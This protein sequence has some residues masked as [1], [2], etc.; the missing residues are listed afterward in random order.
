M[1]WFGFVS[2]AIL[3]ILTMKVA[4][5]GP[6]GAPGVAPIE[7]VVLGTFHFDNPGLDYASVQV[8]DVL[9]P[10]RQAQIGDLLDHL[11][12]YV[13]TK[14][15]VESQKRV[16]G[17][18]YSA[19]YRRF[20]AGAAPPNRSEVTQL[21]YRL[22]QRLRHDEVYATDFDGEFPFEPVMDW[23]KQ[24]G[25]EGQ[26]EAML[27]NTRERAAALS[28]ELKTHSLEQVLRLLNSRDHLRADHGF[29]TALL[30]F[31]GGDEQPG[32]RLV[33]AWYA[34]N[35]GICARIV[36]VAQPGDRLLVIYGAGHAWLLR[37]CLAEQPG[38]RILEADAFLRAN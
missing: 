21:G 8:D 20:L 15:V 37:Q 34:R 19:N 33:A 3:A 5:A 25:R 24:S 12:R 4:V 18:N 7:V 11:A 9:A 27:A 2:G 13:P 28:A 32:A 36:Q 29:Y 31:G 1:N 30:G 22:A 6:P 26:I 23:A 10:T 14:I 16:P 38:V 17:T 35:L